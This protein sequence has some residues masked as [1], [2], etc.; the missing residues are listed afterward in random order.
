MN[1]IFIHEL[2]IDTRIGI[3]TREKQVAQTIQLDLDIALR[4]KQAAGV[5]QLDESIDY[6]EV[7][8]RIRRLFE[9]EHFDLLE[10]AAETIARIIMDE[11]GAPWLRITIAKLAPLSGVKRL[12][13]T[14][15]RGQPGNP[16]RQA[17]PRG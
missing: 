14:I 10:N 1:M 15:E 5:W 4:D 2:R 12:G 13:V 9:E 6:A 3:Y 7:V 11:F 16:A 17:Y 8:K